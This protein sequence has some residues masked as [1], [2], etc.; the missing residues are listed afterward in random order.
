MYVPSPGYDF[1]GK[2]AITGSAAVTTGALTIEARDM[3]FVQVR[4]LGYSGGGDIASF[5]FNGDTGTNYWSR[6]ISAASGGT[7]LT[8][9][10][11][12]S[13]TLARLHPTSTTLQ[14]SSTH[15]ITNNASTSKVGTIS[16]QTG[17]GAAATTPVIE[18][19]GFEWVNT[20]AQI[21]SIE[22]RTAGGSV[23]MPVGTGFAV[24]GINLT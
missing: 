2:I 18:W 11:N 21:T 15:A 13:A 7:T 19:G 12:A 23:T 24:W 22:L 17:S 20:S 4:V 8:N 1:L 3:L 9:A 14:R 6:S 16:A 5:R 10:A